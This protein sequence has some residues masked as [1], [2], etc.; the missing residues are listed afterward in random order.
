MAVIA[1]VPNKTEFVKARE[2]DPPADRAAF[3]YQ[4]ER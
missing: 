4:T 2:S 1:G 3:Y